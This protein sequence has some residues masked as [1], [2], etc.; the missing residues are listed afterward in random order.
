M[1]LQT[2][3]NYS[4]V[5]WDKYL[6]SLLEFLNGNNRRHHQHVKRTLPMAFGLLAPPCHPF[7]RVGPLPHK[8]SQWLKYLVSSA[9]SLAAYLCW[10]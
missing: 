7:S 3:V 10:G 5:H 6:V 4:Y 2:T 8:P 9:D 1:V